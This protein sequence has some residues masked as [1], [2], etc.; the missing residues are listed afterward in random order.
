M[1]E[2]N[3]RMTEGWV[4]G[5]VYVDEQTPYRKEDF[6][7]ALK[8]ERMA[9]EQWW[10]REMQVLE[11]DRIY[12]ERANIYAAGYAFFSVNNLYNLGAKM[13]RLYDY[14]PE[15]IEANW[16]IN[17]IVAQSIDYRQHLKNVVFDELEYDVDLVVNTSCEVMYPFKEL[18]KAYPENT[19]FILQGTNRPKKGNINVV[20][21]L[22]AFHLTTGIEDVLYEGV[23][24]EG[25]YERYMVIGS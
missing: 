20:P 2:L 18:R 11:K 13:V 25:D 16:R 6:Y 7:N 4:D 24:K 3:G 5:L 8:P 10:Y 23:M 9:Q 21:D 12:I 1:F 15:V 14:D 17:R 22:D 19:L